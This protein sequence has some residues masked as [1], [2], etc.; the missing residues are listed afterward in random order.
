METDEHLWKKYRDV[1]ENVKTAF[2]TITKQVK[3]KQQTKQQNQC[4]ITC[5]EC[6]HTVACSRTCSRSCPFLLSICLFVFVFVVYS[7][8]CCIHLL[9]LYYPKGF[10]IY[11]ASHFSIQNTQPTFQCCSERAFKAK[12]CASRKRPSNSSWSACAWTRAEKKLDLLVIYWKLK[13]D[14][15]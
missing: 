15:N 8:C 11:N 4:V 10:G 3:A 2:P 14:R 6:L 9:C 5:I 7:F 13:R 1:L 12:A